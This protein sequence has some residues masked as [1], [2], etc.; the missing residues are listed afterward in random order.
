MDCYT[1]IFPLYTAGRCNAAPDTV[2]PWVIKQLHYMSEHFY[3][4]NAEIVAQILELQKDISPWEVYAML[5]SY[6]FAA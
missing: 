3:V 6:A 2:R 1:L 4:R 5:G